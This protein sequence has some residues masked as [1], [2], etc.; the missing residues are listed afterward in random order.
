MINMVWSG[1]ES[2]SYLLQK[3]GSSGMEEGQLLQGNPT[4]LKVEATNRTLG[5][6]AA[7]RQI[8]KDH[9]FGGTGGR[10]N[11]PGIIK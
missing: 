8:L 11:D 2:L 3:N 4:L 7:Q 9:Q 1:L 10:C 5:A 6:I